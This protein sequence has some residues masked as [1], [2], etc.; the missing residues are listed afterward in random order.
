MVTCLTVYYSK[1]RDCI[2][3]VI[4]RCLSTAITQQNADHLECRRDVLFRNF[5]IYVTAGT[6]RKC[7]DI[8]D[9]IQ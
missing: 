8:C 7:C 9:S 6:V 5:K 3:F 4:N 1:E 2:G